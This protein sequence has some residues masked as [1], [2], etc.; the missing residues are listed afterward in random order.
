MYGWVGWDARLDLLTAVKSSKRKS[1]RRRRRTNGA[2]FSMR[3][4]M[5]R[6]MVSKCLAGD[7]AVVAAAFERER[8]TRNGGG[9]RSDWQRGLWDGWPIHTEPTL[10]LSLRL[11]TIFPMNRMF[12][13]F[14]LSLFLCRSSSLRP[15]GGRRAEWE[16][17]LMRCCCWIAR[18]CAPFTMG[19]CL[20]EKETTK[21][22]VREGW[23]VV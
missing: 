23:C 21:G 17:A 22:G 15:M 13:I 9:F 11:S 4:Q 2:E 12:F 18:L 19:G 1:S 8:E 16:S 6:A 20:V 14:I 5:H 10:S 7:A 3:P